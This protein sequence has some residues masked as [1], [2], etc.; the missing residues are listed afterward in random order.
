MS[1]LHYIGGKHATAEYMGL[2]HYRRIL[3]V[4]DEDLY[5]FKENDIDVILPY[6]TIHEPNI[7]EHHRRYLNDSD[8]EAMLKA[9]EECA[10]D[11]AAAL[12]DIFAKQYFYNYNMLIAKEEIFKDY[13]NWMFPI[14][15]RTEELSIPKGNERADRYI[16]Y[17]GENLTTLYFMYHQKDYKIVHAGRRM[18]I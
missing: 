18:L 14:L 16:G 15:K 2:F 10:P 8:W 11:Y 6:P 5:R 13:C 7:G 17:L 12:P 1:F 3:D 9:L 4:Q